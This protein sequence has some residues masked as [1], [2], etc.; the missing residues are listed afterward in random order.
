MSPRQRVVASCL[1]A[2]EVVDLL[3]LYA[4]SNS[5]RVLSVG[6]DN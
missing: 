2:M 3:I 1:T 4:S 5:E 6:D